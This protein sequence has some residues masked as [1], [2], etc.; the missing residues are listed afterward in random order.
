MSKEQWVGLLGALLLT[1]P[2]V[3]V[4]FK[5]LFAEAEKELS[6][7][8]EQEDSALRPR[9]GYYEEYIEH[10][11]GRVRF[12]FHFAFPLVVFF[13]F[14]AVFTSWAKDWLG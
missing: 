2:L 7:K 8:R 12:L 9:R 1:G 4:L 3:W 10:L 14:W 6:A 13:L 11:F 5:G